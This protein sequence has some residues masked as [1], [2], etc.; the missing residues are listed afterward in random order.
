MSKLQKLKH[1]ISLELLDKSLYISAALEIARSV[2]AFATNRNWLSF[3]EGGVGSID[4]LTKFVSMFSS[5]FFNLSQGWDMLICSSTQQPLHDI[6]T[7]ILETF[8][9]KIL[10]FHY[11]SMQSMAKLYTLPNGVK[12][13]KDD[14]GIWYYFESSKKDD[15]LD[16]LYSEIFKQ[17]K[18]N[19][20]S[21]V[22]KVQ[23]G[24]ARLEGNS[25]FILKCESPISIPSPT[26]LKHLKHIKNS[27]DKGVNRSIIFVGNAG[28]G[29]STVTSTIMNE[30][31]LRTLK[32][33]YD[34]QVTDLNAIENIID[35]LKVE[36][37]ILDDFDTV[38]GS[39]ALLGFLEIMHVK[40]KLTIGV[41]NSL[42]PF[43]PAIL[44]PARFDEIITINKLDP[45]VIQ[46][47]LGPR[48]KALFPK[49]KNWPVA[50]IK[51]LNDRLII[52]PKINLVAQI[53]ELNKRIKD[54][55]KALNIPY[56][57]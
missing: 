9:S 13:G 28:T 23:K 52:N 43:N 40:L 44:R 37:L 7:P 25:R 34:P 15:L 19:I 4:T 41:V 27:I 16:F 18:S 17:I 54:Q 10:N 8:P 14:Y 33:K 48:F 42:A 51:E 20:F 53:K 35:A 21:I 46:K 56:R 38:D 32:F 5:D 2:T 12:L 22:E 50:Y 47:I 1:R 49:V 57:E 39:I 26:A 30:L 45:E 55:S 31:N 24:S 3:V 36:A 6:V 29:K 11:N